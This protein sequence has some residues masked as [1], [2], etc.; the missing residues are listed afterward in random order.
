MGTLGRRSFVKIGLT[1]ASGFIF[2]GAAAKSLV[3]SYGENPD[4]NILDFGAEA[5][6]KTLNTNAIQKAI[7][8][9]FKKGGGRVIIP[10]G[11]FLTG[12]V[13]LKSKVTLYL[14][15]DAVLLAS[16]FFKDFPQQTVRRE[17]RYAK[18]LHRALIV[19]QGVEDIAVTGPGILDGNAKLDGSGEFKERNAENPSFIWFDECKNVLVKDVTFRRSVWWTQAYTRCGNVH[20]D[21]ITVT[22]N[23]FYNAD[24]CDIV[25]CDDFIVE[26]C[27]INA[28]DDGICLK[29]YTREGCQRGIIRNNKVRTLCNGIKMGTDSSGGFRD[30][31]IEDNE[32]WQTGISGIALQ[33]VDGGI[34]ENIRVRNIT[35]NGVG[36]PI[37]L[38]LGD[39]NRKVYGEL[40]VQPGI[41]RNVYIGD[42]KAT[43]NKPKK[44]NDEERKRLNLETYA[45]SICGIPGN[46][47][48]DITI[49]NVSITILEGFPP[50]TAEDSL[51][52]I[53]EVSKKY[54]ENRMFGTLPS[55]GFYIRHARGIKMKNVNVEVK[56]KDGRPAFI[57]DDVHDSVFEDIRAQ[58]PITTPAVT[59]SQNCS[60]IA[61]N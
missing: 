13:V 51:R 34:M 10:A 25:D 23:Y 40:G 38:R 41:L 14:E 24:G 32:V 47:I 2:G 17:A 53:P 48:Q 28:N 39:R 7:D 59:V 26:N 21:H 9:C 5:N 54:P 61:L 31:N 8:R 6:G 30:I 20:I 50:A 49:E 56:Q 46:H 57:L 44:F 4:I 11:T 60:D 58:N 27:D 35:M 1:G 15:K 19:A 42:I 18:Y 45:S 52:E 3:S 55:Y 22:E 36:T 12:S 43:V 16:P 33:I 37:N 29:G